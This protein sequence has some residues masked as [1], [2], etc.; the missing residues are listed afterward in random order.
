MKESI[1]NSILIC[2][3]LTS[4]LKTNGQ[5]PIKE[6]DIKQIEKSISPITDTLY[7]GKYEV[8][9]LLY[10]TFE[11]ALI[12]T[13]QFDLLKFAKVDSTVWKYFA[14]GPYMGLYHCHP[15]Y[16]H[17]PVVGISYEAVNLFCKWLSEKYNSNPK[18]KYKKVLFRLPT[19]KEWE[20]AAYGGKQYVAYA[21]GNQ[22]IQNKYLMCNFCRV[23]DEKIR[24]DTINKKLVVDLKYNP[25]AYLTTISDLEDASKITLPVK[26]YFPNGIGLYNVC[27][28][29]AEIVAE[30]GIAKGG[31]WKCPG[32]DVQITSMSYYSKPSNDIGFRYFME[33]IEK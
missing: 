14:D 11:Q 8:D 6:L 4:V 20:R 29:V 32:A 7:A 3:L 19:E 22:L 9:N 5:T 24:Y 15:A 13:N 17:Y 10:R 18:R 30:N 1:L 21:W 23:G 12:N 25:Y 31:S 28:N 33:V 27:G 2:L 16:D 26:S